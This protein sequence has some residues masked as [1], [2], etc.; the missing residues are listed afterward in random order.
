MLV[1]F[2]LTQPNKWSCDPLENI[3]KRLE[4][5]KKGRKQWQKREC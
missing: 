5:P 1:Q 4:N 2:N 3:L